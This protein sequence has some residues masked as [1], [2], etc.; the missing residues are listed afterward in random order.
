MISTADLFAG[1]AL[2]GR[3]P[4]LLAGLC[5]DSRQVGPG[6]AYVAMGR[7][8]ELAQHA[9]QAR[10]AGATLVVGEA[11]AGDQ[12]AYLSSPHARWT[13]ARASVVQHGLQA[14]RQPLVAVCGT[15]G[16]STTTHCAW[17]AMGGMETG[18]AR[19][20][21]IGWHDGVDERPNPQTTPPP[22]ELHAFLAGLPA[23]CPGV[24]MEIS[25]HAGDQQRAAGLRLA[26]LAFT[27]LGHDHLDYHR[28]MAAYL[29]AK[30]RIVRQLVPGAWCIINADDA[31]AHTVAHAAAAVQ[32]RVIRLGLARG[33]A[34]LLRLGRDWRLVHDG[35]DYP[36]PVRLPG[37]FNAWNA[38]AGAL[39][40]HAA[41]VP[42][43]TALA[44]LGTLEAVPGRL[45][46]LADA[47]STY[48]DYAHTPD[49]I[50]AMLRALRREF[51]GRRLV[52]V[53][54]C[55]G[56]RDRSKRGPMGCAALEADIAVLTT[57]NSR[58]ESP[59][60]IADD[61]LRGLPERTD[62]F[63]ANSDGAESP[64]WLADQVLLSCG[65]RPEPLMVVE[66][67]RATAIRLA[68]ALA[69][70]DGIA[71]VAGKGHETCQ[72]IDGQTLAWDDRAFVRS[73]GAQP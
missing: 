24:A 11:P 4:G 36:L 50:A 48:V 53:F 56:D 20:G 37:A 59:R 5:R 2:S 46:L 61:V 57:D 23:R 29:S 21:T 42:L 25:S 65:Q 70:P 3:A 68:R 52:C 51:P 32:A 6:M 12:R 35:I 67:D 62:V 55:G 22:E 30:L 8:E 66:L 28:T 39:L 33:D 47:P 54:G 10:S 43:A 34:R 31:H 63:W 40:A 71:V 16:K 69:G 38:A 73:C 27:G 26:G 64:R 41:G 19:I 72:L 60:A 45:E 18:A 14:M 58:R 49:E 9:A 44:R 1:Q 17:W 7:P 15:A 13:F